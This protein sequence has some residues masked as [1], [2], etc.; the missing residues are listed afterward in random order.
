MKHF[1]PKNQVP[2]VCTS[3]G[4]KFPSGQ[5]LGSGRGNV[6][7][8]CTTICPKCG[9]HAMIL[10]SFTDSFGKLHVR[11]IFVHVQ[12]FSDVEKLTTLKSNLE[13]ANEVISAVELTEVLIEV[14]P[15]FA[16]FKEL[17]L[18]LPIS[19]IPTLINIL[20]Q[21]IV[22]VVMYKSMLNTEE[23]HEENLELQSSQLELSREQF[24]YQKQ[25]DKKDELKQDKVDEDI[26]NLKTK[27]E[28][29]KEYF[30]KELNNHN[31]NIQA[32]G[33]INK[34]RKLHKLKGNCRNKPCPC[35]SG[36]KAKKCHPRGFKLRK[37]GSER[38]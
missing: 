20:L 19:S 14:D 15:A 23:N 5:S 35:G 31:G 6:I 10:D 25:K 36:R 13:A 7:Q 4:I 17:I 22:L 18:A 21:I 30:V 2:A 34:S 29:L 26:D 8:G 28:D 38:D 12:H 3:C 11:D 1:N 37:M 33:A 16:K 27:I 9:G 24:E 32:S